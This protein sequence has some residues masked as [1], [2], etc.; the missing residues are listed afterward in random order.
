MKKILFILGFLWISNLSFSQQKHYYHTLG[1]FD[2]YDITNKS[3]SPEKLLKG[4]FTGTHQ[5]CDGFNHYEINLSNQSVV[6]NYI[7]TASG[8][9]D[10]KESLYTMENCNSKSSHVSLDVMT[11]DFGKMTFVV[12]KDASFKNDLVVIFRENNRTYAATIKK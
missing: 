1:G 8:V 9:K 12:S 4:E 11:E 6:H 2:Y 7:S 3:V 5:F 10:R